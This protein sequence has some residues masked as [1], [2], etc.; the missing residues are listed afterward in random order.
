MFP[1]ISY[2]E[3]CDVA[4]SWPTQCQWAVNW[5][6][7]VKICIE[8]L[9]LHVWSVEGIKQVLSDVCVFDHTEA[10][11]FSQEN[12]MVFSFVWM[13]NPDLLARSKTVTFFP[14]RAS[15]SSSSDGLPSMD[16]P[17]SSPLVKREDVMLIHLDH[18]NDW[19]LS[20][21]APQAWAL[22]GCNP[23]EPAPL[24]APSAEGLLDS[25]V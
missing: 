15:C 23:P 2:P 5:F 10:T 13:S 19:T 9:P 25:V 7:Y 11:M 6:Y 1:T 8:H 12:I 21:C 22:T 18:Y 4:L 20:R 24:M 14:E 16:T 3:Q 17:Q